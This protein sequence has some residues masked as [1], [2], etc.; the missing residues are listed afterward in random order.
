MVP[1]WAK[2]A[3][4][5][6]INLPLK[7]HAILFRS[8][9]QTGS[10]KTRLHK[11]QQM[12]PLIAKK[13]SLYWLMNGELSCRSVIHPELTYWRQVELVLPWST[14]L[15]EVYSSPTPFFSY[16]G[17][18]MERKM[19]FLWIL[20][21]LFFSNKENNFNLSSFGVLLDFFRPIS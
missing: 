19:P 15:G 7:S 2:R 4:Q 3:Q 14:F 17:I 6:S 8:G 12:L 5:A 11:A 9:R 10:N 1:Q 21:H 20:I 18:S 13:T 16:F